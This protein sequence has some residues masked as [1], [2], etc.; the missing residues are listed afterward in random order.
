MNVT[1]NLES[2]M[3]GGK[4]LEPEAQLALKVLDRAVRDYIFEKP[5][6]KSWTSAKK[7]LFSDTW[8]DEGVYCLSVIAEIMGCEVCYIRRKVKRVIG[9][10]MAL[11]DEDRLRLRSLKYLP[12]DL[13]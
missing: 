11:S 4:R 10:W 1:I 3:Q 13:G 8:K 5:G 9:R 2:Y 12:I 6:G 7:Y